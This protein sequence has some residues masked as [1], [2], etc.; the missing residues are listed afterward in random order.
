M[1]RGPIPGWAPADE[2]SLTGD[3]ARRPVGAVVGEA[4]GL[5]RRHARPLLLMTAV[6]EV[7]ATL[8]ALPYLILTWSV[9]AE[10]LASLPSLGDL[11]VP[12]GQGG[13]SVIFWTH[14]L[15]DRY[16]VLA[17]P[18]VGAL[19]GAGTILPYVA[20]VILAALIGAFLLAP[21]SATPSPRA[22]ARRTLRVWLPLLLLSS[23]LVVAW[24]LLGLVS[25]L[26]TARTLDAQLAGGSDV[27]SASASFGFGLAFLLLFGAGVYV[28]ARCAFVPQAVTLEATGLR[29]AIRRSIRLTR[30][31]VLH[32]ILILVLGGLIIGFA[33]GLT[34]LV[35]GALGTLLLVAGGADMLPAVGIVGGLGYLVVQV[36]LG[37]IVPLLTT[38]LYRDA[39]NAG[40][41]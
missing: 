12:D 23:I 13:T 17:D 3:A 8:L 33:G 2:R 36:L 20:M 32:V 26:V 9:L 29:S 27:S 6:L 38:I 11:S 25:A 34:L 18:L 19:G 39:R 14:A 41:R 1:D 4:F 16:R 22:A 37:P 31:R 35:V 7:P 28:I 21:D 15:T 5:Y 24:A 10:S 30:R 40:E